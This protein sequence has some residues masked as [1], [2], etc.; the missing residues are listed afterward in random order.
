[1]VPTVK[2]SFKKFLMIWIRWFEVL[3][4]MKMQGALKLFVTPLFGALG[5]LFCKV[6]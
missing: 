6:A 2:Q 3:G 1:M 5:F 4:I